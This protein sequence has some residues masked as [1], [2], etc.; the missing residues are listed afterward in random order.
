MGN[1]LKHSKEESEVFGINISRLNN[2]D[3]ENEAFYNDAIE[4]AS[5]IIFLHLKNNKHNVF[6]K[7]ETLNIPHTLHYI[8][9]RSTAAITEELKFVK[10]DDKVD[11]E[12]I[13]YDSTIHYDTLYNF[14]KICMDET[15]SYTYQHPFLTEFITPDLYIDAIAKYACTYDKNL[16]KNKYGF[17]GKEKETGVLVGFFLLEIVDDESA[18]AYMGGVM[19]QYRKSGIAFN[20]Y[21]KIIQGFLIPRGI[22]KFGVDIHIQNI[23]NIRSAAIGGNGLKPSESFLRIN[24]FPFINHTKTETINGILMPNDIAVSSLILEIK[25]KLNLPNEMYITSIRN[26]RLFDENVLE[27][28][29]S[30]TA[31]IVSDKMA[32][33]LLKIKSQDKITNLIYITFNKK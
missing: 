3:F 20:A 24:L 27:D 19:P 28:S 21:L 9:V 11:Y 13:E 10:E 25:N 22:K 29:Y 12:F 14:A 26:V 17:F 8:S 16:N 7:L 30:L 33:A 1:I 18:I 4:N 31:P 23:G 6:Q 5:D 32:L 15:K 2:I